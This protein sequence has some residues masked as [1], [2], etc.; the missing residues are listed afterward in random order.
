MWVLGRTH[1]SWAELLCV[2]DITEGDIIQSDDHPLWEPSLWVIPVY[3]P[4]ASCILHRTWTGD[5]SLI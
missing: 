2:G 3:Q 5:S 4:Q 1:L